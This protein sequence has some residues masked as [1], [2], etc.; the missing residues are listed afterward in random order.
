MANSKVENMHK[1]KML[2]HYRITLGLAIQHI[3][4]RLNW[5]YDTHFMSFSPQTLTQDRGNNKKAIME[6]DTRHSG[7]G[8]R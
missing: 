6:G 4:L 8:T 5:S 2:F 7:I 3:G 1:S